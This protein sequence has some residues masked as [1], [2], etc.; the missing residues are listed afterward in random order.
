MALQTLVFGAKALYWFTYWAPPGS[1]WTSALIKPDGTRAPAYDDVKAVNAEVK[2]LGR[3]L[4]DASSVQ[5]ATTK[6]TSDTADV[7]IASGDQF[8]I[9]IFR[10]GARGYALIGN[11]DYENPTAGDIDA[12]TANTIWKLDTT[13]GSWVRVSA[14]AAPSGAQRFHV[15]LDAGDAVLVGW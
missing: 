7:A 6:D 5:I 4:L 9:W 8:D 15:A 12:V 10:S 14:T 2:A 1:M 11:L 13:H 3:F